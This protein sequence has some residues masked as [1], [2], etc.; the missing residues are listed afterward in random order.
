MNKKAEA[1]I[2]IALGAIGTLILAIIGVL[3]YIGVEFNGDSIINEKPFTL[4]I[5]PESI[6]EGQYEEKDFTFNLKLNSKI[7]IT[8]FRLI[9]DNLILDRLN[10]N[11]QTKIAKNFYNWKPRNNN[12]IIS[13]S[14]NTLSGKCNQNYEFSATLMGCNNCFYGSSFPYQ[15]TYTITYTED[16]EEK[17]FSDK[18]L[19]PIN[20]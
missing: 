17:M 8:S 7:N 14:K 10:K 16:N 9:E 20:D 2:W 3:T 15:L 19:I 12:Y 11:S 5:S 4:T 13:C 18:I 6:N 1:K